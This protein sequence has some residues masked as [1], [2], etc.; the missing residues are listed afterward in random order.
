MRSFFWSVFSGIRTEYGD[1]HCIFSPNTRKYGREKILQE[2][3]GPE[4][5]LHLDTFHAVFFI[6]FYLLNLFFETYISFFIKA[7]CC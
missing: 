2:K 1:L 4:K 7:T 3:Y 5:T 6:A